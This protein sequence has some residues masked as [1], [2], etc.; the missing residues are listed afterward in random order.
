M[1]DTVL[2]RSSQSYSHQFRVDWPSTRRCPRSTL[3]CDAR[4]AQEQTPCAF[5]GTESHRKTSRMRCT[6]CSCHKAGQHVI[7]GLSREVWGSSGSHHHSKSTCLDYQE[8]SRIEIRPFG[9]SWESAMTVTESSFCRSSCEVLLSHQ[10]SEGCST[11]L[12]QMQTEW[13][14]SKQL[15]STRKLSST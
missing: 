3:T 6:P 15:G 11:M 12:I 2:N 1:S 13:R 9:S 5:V 4:Q 14:G 10:V 8:I 7:S